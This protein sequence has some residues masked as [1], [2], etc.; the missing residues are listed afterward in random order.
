MDENIKEPEIIEIQKKDA[1]M[2]I[3]DNKTMLSEQYVATIGKQI[4]LRSKL[5]MT[6]LK[7]LKAHDFQDFEGKPYLEGEGAARIMAI[8][9]G[10]KVGEAKFVIEQIAP[11]YFVDCSIPMEFMGATTV[12]IGDCSTSDSFFTGRDGK[13]GRF[14]R[15]V[16]QTGSEIMATRLLLGDA[17]KKSRENAISRG[18][19]ELLG[20]KGLTWTDL[21]QLGFTRA[22]AGSTVIFKQG[23][24]GGETK[25]LT[26]TEA[27]Q[28]KAGSVIDIKAVLVDWEVKQVGKDKKDITSYVLHDGTNKITVKKWGGAKE[29]LDVNKTVFCPKVKTEMY[30]GNLQYLT[31]DIS[32]IESEVKNGNDTTAD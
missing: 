8:V 20:L 16:D 29:G 21:E 27:A 5:I 28:V 25:T 2:V 10:F 15:Y 13:S 17:K 1:N 9:R 24:Q 19:S 6:A 22:G 11:H 3:E 30:Q 14:K 31:E 18:V 4:E 12:A 32:L 23:S 26:V 7:A